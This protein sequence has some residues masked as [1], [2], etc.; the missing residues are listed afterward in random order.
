[1][2]YLNEGIEAAV[3]GFKAKGAPRLLGPHEERALSHSR[4]AS[5]QP[6]GQSGQPRCSQSTPCARVLSV[7]S[8]ARRFDWFSSTTASSRGWKKVWCV[9]QLD[10]EY[11]ARI[12]DVL[13][14]YEREHDPN[15]PVVCLD[16]KPVQLL[17]DVR[18]GKIQ[19]NGIR[20]ID[21]EYARRGTANLFVAVQPKVG[22][23][24]VAATKT[25][26]RNDFAKMVG[27]IARAYPDA[28]RIHLVLDNLNMHR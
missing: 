24:F 4:A 13:A 5:R 25:R 23:Y 10:D 11:V 15:Q 8:G 7:E 21:Y 6:V 14:T 20:R 18:N 28:F 17:A 22:R 3:F 27:R 12:E 26:T 19:A 16:E 9:P 1:M 2:R